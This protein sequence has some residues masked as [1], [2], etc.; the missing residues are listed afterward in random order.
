MVNI[1]GQTVKAAIILVALT[2]LFLTETI[3][4]GLKCIGKAF[5]VLARPKFGQMER[6]SIALQQRLVLLQ[7]VVKKHIS[8]I[9][10][11][12]NGVISLT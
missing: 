6:L 2:N 4:S 5:L 12:I 3:I 7:L 8:L 11:H 1:F 10:K 9:K